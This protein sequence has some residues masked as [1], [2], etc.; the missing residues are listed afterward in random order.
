MVLYNFP[1]YFWGPV[2]T[3]VFL[4]VIMKSLRTY[5]SIIRAGNLRLLLSGHVYDHVAH[6]DQ[7]R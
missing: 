4:F 3:T 2:D 1:L 5:L 7:G 6:V